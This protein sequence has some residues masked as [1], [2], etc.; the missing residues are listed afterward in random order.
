MVLVTVSSDIHIGCS[1]IIAYR[2]LLLWLGRKGRL[3]VTRC[4]TRNLVV[5]RLSKDALYE[6]VCA[7]VRIDSIFTE[8]ASTEGNTIVQDGHSIV[9]DQLTK[10][11]LLDC[12]KEE[13]QGCRTSSDHQ[14]VDILRICGHGAR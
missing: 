4:R 1:L 3:H 5:L 9:L 8:H 14:Y 6:T 10:P 11:L 12:T 7:S 2:L 13:A